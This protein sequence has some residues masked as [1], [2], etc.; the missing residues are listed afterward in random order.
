LTDSQ[1]SVSRQIV[2]LNAEYQKAE[3]SISGFI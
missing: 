3:G 2:T 1:L